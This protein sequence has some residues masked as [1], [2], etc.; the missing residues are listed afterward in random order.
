MNVDETISAVEGGWRFDKDVTLSFDSH[1]RKSVPFYD[2]FQEMVVDMSEWFVGD[3]SIVYDL[4]SSTGE[5]ISLL[6]EKHSR[7][8]NVQFVGMDNSVF[9]VD[10]ATKK[11][12][13]NNVR[14]LL[15]DIADIESLPGANLVISL[16]TLQF[17]PIELR[18]QILDIIFRG[19]SEG[20]ALIIAEKVRGEN[21][22]TEDLW[23]ELYWD[24]KQAQGLNSDQ[25]IQKAKSLRGV[26]SCFPHRLRPV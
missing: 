17:L 25:V 23:V 6:H 4:G 16:Y 10:A 2:G 13:W 19:L 5:T 9:M 3:N 21:S 20:G 14:F 1:V 15:K 7:K 22:L 8:T 18:K 11:C 24:F 12:E 26:F